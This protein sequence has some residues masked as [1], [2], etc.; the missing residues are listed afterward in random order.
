MTRALVW[1]ELREQGAVL[2]ALVVMGCAVLSAAAVLLDPTTDDAGFSL[3]SMIVAGRLGWIMLTMTAGV[4]AGGTLF[5]GER[6]AG[7]FLFLDLLPVSRWRVWWRKVAIGIVLTGMATAVLFATAAVAGIF[8][9]RDGL[10][11]WGLL[12][13][14]L[15]GLAF[16]WGVMGSVSARSSL[17]ACALA[18]G[19]GL[20]AGVFVFFGWAIVAQVA[21]ETGLAQSIRRS[22]G[23]NESMAIML[24]GTF[25]LLVIPLPLAG[26]VYTAPDRNR[27]LAKLG[28]RFPGP[29]AGGA[30]SLLPSFGWLSGL[31]R[32]V[33]LVVRQNRVPAL[34]LCAAGL[35][36]GIFLTPATG[37]GVALYLWPALSLLAGVL[38]AVIGVS[39]EQ[40]NIAVR[41]WGER[42]MPVGRLWSVKILAGLAILSCVL[43]ALAFPAFIAIFFVPR[44]NRHYGNALAVVFGSGILNTFRFPWVSYLFVWPVYGFA[45]GHLSALL[46]RKG[47]VAGMVALMT[48]G[49]FAALW[50]PSLLSGGLHLWQVF[51]P[52]ALVLLT[53][54]LLTWPWA[55]DR[56]GTRAPLARVAVGVTLAL[57]ALG[58]GIGYRA[59]EV[60]D[61]PGAEDDIAFAQTL[62][63][64]EDEQLGRDLKRAAGDFMNVPAAVRTERVT[65]PFVEARAARTVMEDL[66]HAPIYMIPPLAEPVHPANRGRMG[67]D[68]GQPYYLDQLTAAIATTGWPADRPD[69]DKWMA[70]M[71]TVHWDDALKDFPTKPIGVFE[72]PN[73]LS[74]SYQWRPTDAL[75]MMTP[76]YLGRGLQR[77]S[78]GDQAA[79]PATLE[80]WLAVLRTAQ[81]KT[82]APVV[83]TAWQSEL[84]THDAT[85]RW[86]EHLDGRPDLL[87]KALRLYLAHEQ[88]DPYDPKTEK[89]AHEVVTRYAVVAPSRWMPQHLEQLRLFGWFSP[90]IINTNPSPPSDAEAS[91]VGFAW[92]IPWER[93]RLWRSVGI[94]GLVPP[95]VR[96]D[97]GYLDGAPG[98]ESIATLWN[99]SFGGIWRAN[100]LTSRRAMILKLALR[101]HEAENGTLPPDLSKLVPK[102]LPAVPLDPMD[103]KPLRYRVS[104]GEQLTRVDEQGLTYS[105]IP[106]P[107]PDFVGPPEELAGGSGPPIEGPPGMPGGPPIVFRP[108]VI[109]SAHRIDVPAG[110]GLVWSVGPDRVDNDAYVVMTV[111][112]SSR[113]IDGD[114]AFIVPEF[115]ASKPKSP[116]KGKP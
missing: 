15:A 44:E 93:E 104:R 85:D 96:Y 60:P 23:G 88:Q 108:T 112:Q 31:R 47:I 11:A 83:Q 55:T 28:V 97:H 80:T 51:A 48:A 8:G 19:F 6:E 39:D 53:A 10:A 5:A 21:V 34:V 61:V 95:G 20:A 45:F 70:G 111:R 75:R 24:A 27:H 68:P 106:V 38:V 98:W 13:C 22:V 113:I 115:Q 78:Q 12:G 74:F 64:L 67:Q 66:A 91:L 81:N 101:L 25:T 3:R 77:Q 57:L 49:T 26:W 107:D 54:R 32:L 63:S 58:L 7:T 116:G 56:I 52:P 65:Q 102:Y 62:P 79:F 46:F 94:A 87:Q 4:V 110:R 72:N 69:L 73:E 76:V 100:L 84:L 59:V 103:G 35:L 114:I 29:N 89:L 41:F 90:T 30:L 50:V 99:P 71:F 40:S 92:T 36:A 33:W 37:E 16:G 18:V 17:E 9:A 2:V 42:R 82:L 109:D 43:V 86:L 1:K 105:P 14:V